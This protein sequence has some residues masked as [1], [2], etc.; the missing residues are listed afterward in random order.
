M[1]ISGLLIVLLVGCKSGDQPDLGEVTGKVTLDGAPLAGVIV[2]FQPESGRAGSAET[3]SQGNYKLVYRY[4]VD[5]AK[6][7]KNTVSFAWPTGAEDKPG[8]PAKYSGQTDLKREVKSG[9]NHF[10]F[11]LKSE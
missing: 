7:G 5:G 2:M 10:D 9:D 4:G 6:V 11:E 1:A 8:L 3:D